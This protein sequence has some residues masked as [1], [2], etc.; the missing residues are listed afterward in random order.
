[1]TGYYTP[2]GGLPPQ[3]ALMTG[4]AIFTEAYAFIP[5]GCFSDIVTSYLPGWTD[6]RLWLIARPM[7]G[8]SETFSQYVM[9]VGPDGGS[10]TPDAEE[11]AEH[12]LFVTDGEMWLSLDGQE[13]ELSAGGYAYIPPGC[14]WHV[15]NG[16]DHP[17]RFHWVRKLYERVHGLPA[18]EA[19]VTNER[20]IA[21]I[22]MPDT[23][24]RWAT[25]RFVDPT[26]LRHDMH[27]NIVTF[28]PGGLIPF[29]ETHVM[30]HGLYVLEGKAVYKLN[31]DWVEVEAGDFMWLR[32][33][34]PQACY[35]AG[36]G[37][38]RYLLYKDVN[39]HAKLRGPFAR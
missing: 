2:P 38:F 14:T 33:Y 28:Q 21:P 39:R 32:A 16:A 20:E 23:Q 17:L 29:E 10:D 6:T 26:D 22:A 9:E 24:G 36:P 15:R 7:T 37:P 11:G 35:A 18:P 12:V 13:Y 30:E 34:C 31:T 3:T 8:F 27:V 25:T 1:M 19:F 4:R 5:K